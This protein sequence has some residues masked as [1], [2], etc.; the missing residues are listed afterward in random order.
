MAEICGASP[1]EGSER[2]KASIFFEDNI[3]RDMAAEDTAVLSG[4]PAYSVMGISREL[5]GRNEI[6]CLK[7]YIGGYHI[8]NCC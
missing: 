6:E 7:N 4:I 3:Q 8:E 5:A 1:H 2:A